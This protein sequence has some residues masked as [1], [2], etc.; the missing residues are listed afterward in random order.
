[1]LNL[2]TARA[3]TDL[4]ALCLDGIANDLKSIHN[5]QSPARQVVLIV[6]AQFTLQAEEEAFRR[7]EAKGFFDFHVMSGAR[8][9]QQILKECGFPQTAPINTLGR[10]ML[11]R[12]IASQQKDAMQAFGSVCDSAEFLKMAGDFLVQM[13]QNDLQA[14]DLSALRSSDEK[15]SLLD[16]KLHDMQLLATGYEDAMAEKFNDS[17]DML[18]FVTE[19]MPESRFVRESIF[20]YYGFYSF[21]R[22]EIAFLRA[23]LQQSCALKVCLRMGKS[24]DADARLFAPSARSAADLLQAAAECGKEAKTLHATGAFSRSLCEDFAHLERNFAVLPPEAKEGEPSHIRLVRCSGPLAQAETIASSILSLVRS[25]GL[26][27]DEIVILTEDM[28]GQGNVIRRVCEQMGVPVFADEK[29]AVSYSPAIET[30]ASLLR[31]AAGSRHAS[32]LIACLKPGLLRLPSMDDDADLELF[33]NYCRQYRLRG[34]RLFQPLQYGEKTYGEEGMK[35]LESIRSELA[36]LLQ[37]FLDAME[38]AD[39]VREKSTVFYRFLSETL[40]MEQTLQESALNLVQKQMLDAAEEQQQIWGIFT[41]LLDQCV[42]LLG[43][44][45]MSTEDYASLLTDSFADVKVGL[46]PQAQGRVL[47]GTLSRSL[48]GQCR[49]LF[50]AGVNDGIL[51]K[52]IATEG[53]LTQKELQELKDKG[54]TLAKTDRILQEENDLTVYSA[55]TLPSEQLWVLWCASDF[56]G[57]EL[58]PSPL[59]AQMKAM[60]PQLVQEQ[61]VENADEPLAFIQGKKAAQSRIASAM[62]EAVAQGRLPDPLWQ[63]VYDQLEDTDAVKAGLLFTNA[64]DALSAQEARALYAGGDYSLSPSRLEKFSHCPFHHFVQY[65]LRPQEPQEFEI[66]SMTLGNAHHRCLQEISRWLS[67][68]SHASG[69]AITDPNSRWMTVSRAELEEKMAQIVA[70]VQEEENEGVMKSGA[71][72]SYQAGRIARVCTQFAWVMVLQV[73]KGRIAQMRFESEFRRGGELPPLLIETSMGKVYVEGKIDRLDLLEGENGQYAKVIDY[74]SG[75]N[76][77]DPVQASKGLQLQLCL[78]LEAALEKKD[79]A[80]GGIFY[81]QIEEPQMP[82]DIDALA[83]EELCEEVW[84]KIQTAYKMHGFFVDSPDVIRAIDEDALAQRISSVINYKLTRE[85]AHAKNSGGVSEQE[86]NAFRAAFRKTL[87]ELCTRLMRGELDAAPRKLK[88]GT[89]CTYCDYKGICG[90]DPAFEGNRY[91]K[92]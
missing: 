12:R 38:R 17:E 40:H 50:L 63:E 74:K 22:R 79:A 54:C 33:E 25:E 91:H 69:K 89:A 45:T 20:W 36:E 10:S 68:P 81:Y 9:H 87:A 32:D 59:I 30:I 88:T 13:K 77:F 62:R 76:R 92:Q 58:K 52:N 35:K 55:F 53:I 85:G 82:A 66:S 47:L 6:P 61:D 72:E 18:R 46:L 86:F 67:E 19:K 4:L 39:S 29:R 71:K 5:E 2:F 37:P 78:Y 16:R 64:K 73:R 90:F 34:S 21:T 3:D 83:S 49:A 65:G 8:L 48:T 14:N 1:M 23:L 43:D 7:F 42:E 70:I 24:S 57:K 84:E 28:Q 11:L 27:Y 51:P 56:E 31:F 80:P 15:D 44:E 41:Q 26:S 75:K 60:F